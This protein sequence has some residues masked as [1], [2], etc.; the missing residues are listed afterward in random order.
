MSKLTVP[1]VVLMMLLSVG[2]VL[3]PEG[4]AN[5]AKFC[6]QVRGTTAAGQPN[7]SFS[8]L[9]ACRAGKAHGRRALLQNAL[10]GNTALIS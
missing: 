6:A 8:T 1:L 4:S 7:C 2:F 10:D 9:D 5:A 3:F